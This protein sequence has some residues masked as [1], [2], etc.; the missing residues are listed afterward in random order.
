MENKYF[1]AVE[2]KPNNYF[3]INLLDLKIFSYTTT[4]LN[5]LD[6]LTLEYTKKEIMDAIRDANLLE[7]ED[8]MPLIIM[9]YEKEKTRKIAALTKDIEFDMWQNLNENIEDKN[10]RNKIIN[11]LNNKI[12]KEDWNE[13]KAA[14]DK[15][16]FLRKIGVLAYP[17][18]RKLYFY[19][20]EN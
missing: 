11:F 6:S 19:L 9:Y 16:A 2:I 5:E 14:Q 12:E 4:N 7:V 18:Q 10:Y 1:L 17:I 8:N 3:P 15:T 13:L 20:Y